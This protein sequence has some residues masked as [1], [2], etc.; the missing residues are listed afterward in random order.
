MR[1]RIFTLAC[2]ML[3][4]WVGAAL[5]QD[6]T[7]GQGSYPAGM[8]FEPTSLNGASA[9]HTSAQQLVADLIADGKTDLGELVELI[10]ADSADQLDHI[11]INLATQHIYELNAS[12]EVLNESLISSGRRGLDTP[13]GHYTVVNKA[14]K[15]YSE[16]YDAWMLHWMGLT[17]NGEYGMHG[18]EGSSYERLLGGVASHG[19]VRLSRE[20]AADLYTRAY[21]G[22]PIEI[23]NDPNLNLR[24]YEPLS[25][26]AAF[27]VVL[28]VISPADPWELFY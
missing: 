18:L 2:V 5:A 27:S 17:K 13:P 25:R 23:V 14:P 10:L 20:Y 26:E 7:A 8:A 15:A 9:Y 3:L 28:E 6:A 21:V 11:L 22:L 1:M 12:G 16:K 19:C 24:T 4:L